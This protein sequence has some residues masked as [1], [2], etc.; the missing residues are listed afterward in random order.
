M[1]EVAATTLQVVALV[2]IGGGLL[3]ILA[4]FLIGMVIMIWKDITDS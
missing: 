4:A 3:A 2:L 1:I